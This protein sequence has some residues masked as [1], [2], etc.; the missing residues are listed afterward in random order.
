MHPDR[1]FVAD[2]VQPF[3]IGAA[4][5][6]ERGQAEIGQQ[7]HPAF[8]EVDVVGVDMALERPGDGILSFRPAPLVKGV[9]EKFEFAAGSAETDFGLAINHHAN[10][11]AILRMRT[12]RQLEL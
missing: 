1:V 11:G 12:F 7:Q 2:F 3:S 6:N 8:G 5:V 4:R 9:A 10:D